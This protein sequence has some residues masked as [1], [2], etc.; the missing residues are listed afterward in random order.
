VETIVRVRRQKAQAVVELAIAMPIL[1]WFALGTLDFGRV[2]HVY[3]ELTNAAREG[4]RQATLR[5]P[6]CD[7]A[8]IRTALATQ[9]PALFAGSNVN[10]ITLDACPPTDR[11][12]VT[13]TNY[14]FEPVTPFIARAL[15]DGTVIHLTTS[16]TLP[17]LSQ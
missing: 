11:R 10:S 12:T 17:V 5:A 2:F 14:P 4:A 9:Q 16:A 15:G 13:I 1:L 6:A 7:V 8:P 3:I